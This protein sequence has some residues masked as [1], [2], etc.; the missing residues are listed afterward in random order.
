MRYLAL[1]DGTSL[2]AVGQGTWHMGEDR[3]RRTREVEA[4][5]LGI[6]LG[7]TLI[8][9]AEMY[10]DGEAERIVGDAVRDVREQVFIVSKVWPS[11]A[12]RAGV[13]AACRGSLKRLGIDR[14]D[15]YLLHWPARGVPLEETMA[16]FADLVRDGLTRFVGVSNFPL[17]WQTRARELLGPA[18]PLR[19]NQVPY[20]LGDR[21]IER[22]LLP[23][24]QTQ[25]IT[26]MAYA[27]L[28][29]LPTPRT[30]LQAVA[31][32]RGATPEQVALAWCLSRPGVVAIPKA[33]DPDHVRQNAAA[34]DLQLDGDELAALDQ[35]YPPAAGD[36][37]LR[38]LI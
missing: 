32:R 23:A 11:H 4:L 28:R 37:D 31:D 1:P 3:R 9:T 33:V 17:D 14:L 5:R 15:G 36:L 10:A 35:A 20:S 7:M 13:Y 6:A 19:F 27:P 2:A 8:D 29:R 25:G 30:A 21:R 12:D 24:C 26:V 22:T 34:A 16:A 38:F 18:V